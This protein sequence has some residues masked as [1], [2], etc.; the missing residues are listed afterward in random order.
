VLG[1]SL[2]LIVS[3]RYGWRMCGIAGVAFA[4]TTRIPEAAW[5]RTMGR[6]IAHRG[7]DGSGEYV[8][9]GV[10]L[11]H[12]RLAIIDPDSGQQPLGNE[13]G[14]IQITCNGEIYNYLELRE[15][16]VAKG[17]RFRTRSDTEVIVHLYEELGE[18]LVRELNGMFAFAIWD[19]PRR[20]LFLARDRI[21]IKPLYFQRNSERLLFGSE[22]R[23]ILASGDHRRQVDPFALDDYLTFGMVLGPKSI[24][25]GIEQL[26]PGHT[27]A[28]EAGRWNASPKCYWKLEFHTDSKP[29][30]DWVSLVREAV[31]ASVKS[32]LAADVPIG[33]FLSGG[34]DSSAVVASACLQR[35]DPLRT[36]SIGFPELEFSELSFAKLVAEKYH[37]VHREEILTADAAGSLDALTR[38]FDEPFADVS[39][40]PTMAVSKFASESVKVVL[41]GDGGDECFGG[42]P[43]YAHDLRE[44]KVRRLFPAV[45]RQ[46]VFGPLGRCWPSFERLPRP[47]R[48]KTALTNLSMDA[49]AAYA[50]TLKQCRPPL[51]DLLLHPD[52]RRAVAGYFP[53]SSLL[54]AFDSASPRDPLAG[55]IAADFAVTLPDDYL[56]KVDRA[57]MAHGLEVRPPLLDHT[58]VELAARIPSSLKIANGELKSVFKKTLEGRLPPEVVYRPKQGF[59]VPLDKWLRGPLAEMMRDTILGSNSALDGLIDR[60]Q[61]KQ[62][63]ESHVG[64]RGRHGRVLWSLIVLA[65]W[66]EHHLPE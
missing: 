61:A 66:A 18:D 23:A 39:A 59:V 3:V 64:G 12:R 21:G 56:V 9:P 48:W 7:P 20:K 1:L 36:F 58:I 62:L 17:H 50:N 25:R 24:Y 22:P 60:Q 52:I 10:G 51:R 8:A 31:D 27:L 4:D 34:V 14:S 43:R 41:S 63:L 33:A 47:L 32:H 37:T 28:V 19:A 42:Y 53:K 46:A 13:D 29:E 57:S 35:P 11:A 55:M 2:A 15:R 40:I 5:L 38:A 6:A 44:D 16:L 54:H 26:P 65:R 30:A 45:F 49:S